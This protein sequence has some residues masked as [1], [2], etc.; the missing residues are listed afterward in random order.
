VYAFTNADFVRVYK[1][2]RCCA[3]FTR[4]TAPFPICR[5]PPSGSNDYIGGALEKNEGLAEEKLK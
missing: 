5:I 2:G 3:I 1:N 4:T